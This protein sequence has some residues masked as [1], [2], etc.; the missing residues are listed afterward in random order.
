MLFIEKYLTNYVCSNYNKIM[1]TS[2]FNSFVHLRF[3]S[4]DK[5]SVL[6]SH[7]INSGDVHYHNHDFYEICY[8]LDGTLPHYVNKQKLD[9]QAGDVIF[10]RPKDKHVYVRDNNC[11]S[12]HRDI[13]F[14]AAFFES[15]LNFIHPELLSDYHASSVPFK[16]NV[17]TETI[18]RFEKRMNEYFAIPVENVKNRLI[19]ARVFLIEL[20]SYYTTPNSKMENN[21]PFLVNQIIQRLNSR[22]AL[23]SGI[24]Y[25]FSYF[26]YSKSHICHT[27]KK[28]MNIS[29]T[30]YINN[31]RLVNAANLLKY[32]NSSL[33]DISQECGFSSLSYF[34]K[35]FKQKY[36]CT[37]AKFGK[38]KKSEE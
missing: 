11:L 25:I 7:V 23:K 37:P 17:S 22:S 34:N 35:L 20:L 21:Y 36:N 4:S 2:I 14:Q 13:V 9:L 19:F 6:Q 27:F 8:V 18:E 33:Y 29:L 15:V 26:N 30:E 10:L 16:I 31:L 32:T 38:T 24:Q 12:S 5:T 3:S 28:Y 1:N